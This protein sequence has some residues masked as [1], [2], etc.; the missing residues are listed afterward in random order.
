VP[1]DDPGLRATGARAG[2]TTS[3]SPTAVPE[4][5]APPGHR[6][7][8]ISIVVLTHNCA[9]WVER[10]LERHLAVDGTPAVIAVD[11]GSTDATVDIL[12]H[13]RGVEVV[14]LPRNVGAAARN[15]GVQAA[16]TPYV[17]FSDDDT[18][19][20]PD[21]PSRMADLFD[22]HPRLAVVTARIL[23]G[24]ACA[25]DPMC[26]EM[27][28]SPLPAAGGVPGHT[29]LSFLAG[30]S[31]VRRDAFLAAGGYDPRLFIG[32]EEELLA[33]DLV[34]AGWMMRYVPEI[35]AHH[36]PSQRNAESIRHIGLRNTLWFAWLR[37]HPREA[38][39][40][41]AHVLRQA[42]RSRQTL[43]G[44]LMALAGLPWV[45]RERRVVTPELEAQLRVLDRQR[46]RSVARCYRP[47]SRG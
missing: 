21:A 35:V 23:V 1:S 14:S 22:R 46:M 7:R 37:R 5:K 4:G 24:E 18:W 39:R 28:Q 26:L 29:L 41:T 9:D 38:A 6:E 16:R 42:P 17:A 12:R 33:I 2:P 13:H 32:G 31:A 27:A 19:Y 43:R 20:A 44:V 30:V 36:H 25:E 10:T 15:A 8:R 40:W 11:N 45:M 3:A 47:P 34:S